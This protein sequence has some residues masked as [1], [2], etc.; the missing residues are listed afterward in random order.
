[1]NNR[2]KMRIATSGAKRWLEKN[3]LV[4]SYREKK[5]KYYQLKDK[6]KIQKLFKIVGDISNGRS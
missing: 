1:M 5:L 2:Q 4:D 6:G 3:N